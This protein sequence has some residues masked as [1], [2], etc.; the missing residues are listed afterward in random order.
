MSLA[1]G[2]DASPVT[3]R[4]LERADAEALLEVLLAN[5]AFL[6]PWEPAHDDAYFTLDAQRAGIDAALERRDLDLMYPFAIVAAGRLVGRLNIN[7]VVRGAGQMASLGYWVSED[8]GG[9]GVATDAVGQA[10]AYAFGPLN[11]HRL[12]AGTLLHNE[13]SQRVLDKNSFER[14]G[15]APK[16]VRID[17]RW[18]DHVLYQRVNDGLAE[19]P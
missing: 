15:M 12:E 2:Q 18:Q 3:L 5:R 6:Q 11:L 14:Y 16:L 13:R 9:R 7:N 17:G 19:H 8:V 4:T 1:G 10:V